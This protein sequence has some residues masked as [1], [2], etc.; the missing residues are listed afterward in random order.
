VGHVLLF[1]RH[2]GDMLKSMGYFGPVHIQTRL[3]S[4]RGVPWLFDDYGHIGAQDG[5][6]L[7]DEVA[8]SITTTIEALHQAPDAAAAN[9]LRYILFA[10]GWP[11]IID[12]PDKLKKLIQK[13]YAYNF[14]PVPASVEI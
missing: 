4:M 7:D 13:G 5:S 8:F 1:I 2:A 3:A 11:E 12:A 6:K 9:I 14:W 10:V